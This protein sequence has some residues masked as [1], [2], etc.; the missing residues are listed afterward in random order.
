MSKQGKLISCLVVVSMM[1]TNIVSIVAARDHESEAYGLF[2]Q[3]EDSSLSSGGDTCANPQ[4]IVPASE[5]DARHFERLTL[6]SEEFK[7][8]K[9]R[10][11]A[12]YHGEFRLQ[13]SERYSL[14]VE[15]NVVA[16]YV[17]IVGGAGE[18]FYGIWFDKETDTVVRSIS[19]VF[20]FD[21]DQNVIVRF[22]H[23]DSLLLDAVIT[24]DGIVLDAVAYDIEG[25]EVD[26]D[27]TIEA[28][29]SPSPNGSDQP[30]PCL[31]SCLSALGVPIFVVA[32]LSLLCAAVCVITTGLACGGCI[33][34]ALGFWSAIGATCIYVCL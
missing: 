22:E 4:N 9:R 30:W 23:N 21:S 33:A 2:N 25:N 31:T 15:E 3:P 14:A 32:G 27:S 24:Q 1:L 26:L 29:N 13:L 16:V 20:E 19:G 8:F 11:F 17:P 34:A 6:R 7:S 10:L 28:N 5:E 12:N 18:S